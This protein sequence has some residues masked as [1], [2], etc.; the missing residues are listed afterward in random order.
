M[1]FLV[2]S[3]K[4][5]LVLAVPCKRKGP[6]KTTGP[7]VA[8]DFGAC[9]EECVL[10]KNAVEDPLLIRCCSYMAVTGRRLSHPEMPG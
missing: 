3:T 1:P 4:K 2:C 7:V 5:P 8:H 6:D 10:T 9:C